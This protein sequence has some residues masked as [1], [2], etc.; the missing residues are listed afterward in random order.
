MTSLPY[1]DYLAADSMRFRQAVV[2]ADPG[3]RVPTCPDW[4]ADDLL[5]HLGEV[6]WFWAEVVGGPLVDDADVTRLDPGPRPGDRP[7]LLA[8]FDTA[9]ARL[10]RVLRDTP[11]KTPAW[12]WSVEQTAGFTRRRQAHEAMIHRVDAELLTEARTPMDPRLSADGVDEVLRVMFA[13]LPPWASFSGATGFV[14]RIETTDTG[15][16][17][18]VRTGRQTGTDPDDDKPVDEP[19]IEVLEPGVAGPAASISGRAADLD[20]WLWNRPC[21]EPVLRSGSPDA[22]AAFDTLVDDGIS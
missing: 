10:Q 15:E 7:G 21:L 2:A 13:G 9:S 17:W 16:S 22:L 12:T 11:P 6:Q 14:L 4:D 3:A 20:C 1:L 19:S 5:W 8:F 18:L